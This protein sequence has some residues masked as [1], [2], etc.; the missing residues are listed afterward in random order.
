ME[1][2]L[3][4]ADQRVISIGKEIEILFFFAFG[5]GTHVESLKLAR[6]KL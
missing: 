6:N 1:D 5:F 2:Q 4:D 3:D